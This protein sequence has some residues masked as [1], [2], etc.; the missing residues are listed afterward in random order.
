M[1]IN[2]RTDYEKISRR[3]IQRDFSHNYIRQERKPQNEIQEHPD[4]NKKYR[5][6]AI[7]T[8]CQ[9]AKYARFMVGKLVICVESQGSGTTGWYQFVFD[10]D[11][12]KLNS[13]AQWSDNK[14]RYFLESPKL[15]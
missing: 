2:K 13:A 12:V 1:R 6:T 7:N 3:S 4:G 11:R 14:N 15:K 5:I 8:S 10:E 9:Y